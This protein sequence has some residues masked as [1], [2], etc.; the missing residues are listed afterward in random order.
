MPSSI[1]HCNTNPSRSIAPYPIPHRLSL[2]HE[3]STDR[4]ID[5]TALMSIS[6]TPPTNVDSPSESQPT[7]K[8]SY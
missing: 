7:E 1:R 3:N 4:T 5:N 6:L 2:H 8:L